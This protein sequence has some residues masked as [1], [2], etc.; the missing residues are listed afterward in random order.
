MG[1]SM[2]VELVPVDSLVFDPNNAR[3]HDDKNLEAIKG[4]LVKFG[5]QKPIVVTDK[6]VVLAGNGTLAAA[7]ALGWTEIAVVR[8]TLEGFDATAYALADNRTAELAA[9]NDD[10][11]GSQLHSLREIG[12]ELPEIGFDTSYLDDMFKESGEDEPK[13]AK[14]VDPEYLLVVLC[15]NEND[16][17]D[18]FEE[19]RERGLTCKIMS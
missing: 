1:V 6:G 15:A 8:S 10:I 4:S 12:F 18:L 7:K 13:A 2:K 16:Q 11:L 17:R 5:Q 14:D 19:F 9:W 3:K